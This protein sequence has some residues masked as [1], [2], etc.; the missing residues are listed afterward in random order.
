MTCVIT[1]NNEWKKL[2]LKIFILPR[3]NFLITAA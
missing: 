2:L 3:Y 1:N